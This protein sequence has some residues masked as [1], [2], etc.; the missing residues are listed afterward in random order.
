VSLRVV[1]ITLKEARVFVDR[2]HRHHRAPQGGLF[3]I[4]CAQ[5][6]EVV[7]VVVVGRPVARMLQ[8]GFT[9]EV[10][11]LCVLDGVKNGCSM[12]YA[13][14]WR[15]AKAIGYTRLITYILQSESGTSLRAAGWKLIAE[16]RGG[17]L[18]TCPSRPRVD[19]HPLEQKQLWVA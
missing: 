18:W 10:T 11:R 1:P 8:D 15:A 2:F 12:L 9:A 7:G 13:A 3:A 14:A 6:A 16:N 5:G 17:G 4:A 19:T